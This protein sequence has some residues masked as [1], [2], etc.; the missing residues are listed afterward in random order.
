MQ[1]DLEQIRS[2]VAVV[3]QSDITELE[4]ISGSDRI[5]ITKNG[6]GN[7][8]LVNSLV[9]SSLVRSSA[10]GIMQDSSHDIIPPATE[11][12]KELTAIRTPYVGRFFRK[13]TPS[14]SAFVDVGDVVTAGQRVAIVEALGVLHEVTSEIEGRIAKVCLDDSTVV[15]YG[16]VLFLVAEENTKECGDA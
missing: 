4:I 5:T 11:L 1:I 14:A 12:K 9:R 7:T 16:Q 13:S 15:G 2:L 3:S 6:N 10:D 8:V